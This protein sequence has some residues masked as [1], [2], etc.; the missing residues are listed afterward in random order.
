M[1][2]EYLD[3]LKKEFFD[4]IG[5]V[6]ENIK[7]GLKYRSEFVTLF[8]WRKIKDMDISQYVIGKE[9]SFCYWLEQKLDKLGRIRGGSPADKKFGIYFG[10]TKHDT[11]VKYRHLKKKWGNNQSEVFENIK[12][13]IIHLVQAGNNNNINTIELNKISPHF[14]GKILSTYF[15][16]KYLN[17]YSKDHIDHF[18]ETLGICYD[19]KESNLTEKKK[20]LLQYKNNDSFFSTLSNYEFTSFLYNK[21]TPPSKSK[22][23]ILSKFNIPFADISSIKVQVIELEIGKSIEQDYNV[24]TN[25]NTNF[26]NNGNEIKRIGNRGELIVFNF[27]K[28]FLIENAR[29]DLASKVKDVSKKNIGFD[30]LSFNLDGS[31]KFIEVKSTVSKPPKI[32]FFLTKNEYRKAKENESY[33]IYIV[34][35]VNTKTPRIFEFN[36]FQKGCEYYNLEPLLYHVKVNSR[37]KNKKRGKLWI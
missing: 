30:I 5:N 31:E 4:S 28:Q 33:I 3:L 29:K 36:P 11:T 23:S 17:I 7:E 13:E 25:K 35:E 26:S 15:P 18:I 37:R 2:N 22:K 19:F 24:K 34:F 27:E 32:N 8:P 6:R 1:Q 14:R 16:Q 10:K 21:L 12:K 20:A 9:N